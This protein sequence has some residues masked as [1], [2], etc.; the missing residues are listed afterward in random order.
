MK[1]PTFTPCPLTRMLR[2]TV[3]P[4]LGLK[5]ATFSEQKAYDYRG[6]TGICSFTEYWTRPDLI[7]FLKVT[8]RGEVTIITDHTKEGE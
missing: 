8:K 4:A 1:N 5:Q 2:E 3:F 6:V 7:I